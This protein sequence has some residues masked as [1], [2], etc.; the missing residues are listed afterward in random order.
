MLVFNILSAPR[1]QAQA[2]YGNVIGTVTDATGAAV[3]EAK[4]TATD[5]A[6]G[7]TYSAT[8]N[9]DGYYALHNLTP[10]EYRVVVEAGGFKT[11]QRE[12]VPVIVGTSSTVNVALD[13]GAATESITVSGAPPLLETDRAAVSTD[14]SAGQVE[15]LPI[16]NRNFTQLELLLPGSA[17]MP[18]QHGQTEN[19]QG[20]IQINTNGQL[21]S[22]TNFM[23]DGMDN[24]DPVLGI[25]MINP[26]I[27]SVQ[28]FKGTTS[29][30]NAEFSQAGGSVVQ[31]QT[32]S[33][34]NTF[35][36]SLFEFLR[37]DVFQARDP[38]TQHPNTPFPPLRWNQFGGSIG[39]PIKKDK[40]FAFFDYQGTRQRNSGELLTRVPTAAERAGD[41]SAL[42][43]AIYDPTTGDQSTGATGG[44][45]RT[46]FHDL[47]R[48]T[49]ANP[50]GLNIIPKNRVLSQSTNL[51]NLLP[52]PNLTPAIASDPNYTASGTQ[53]FDTNQFDIRVDHYLTSK[54]N[55][56]ARYSY[57]GYHLETPGAFGTAG[58]PQLNGLS[59]EGISNV[60]NQNGVGAVN[61]NLNPSM[62]GDF[63]FGVTRYRVFVTSPDATKMLAA[64]AG[65]PGL[66]DPTRKD[67]W[68]LPDVNV[69]NGNGTSN[70][71]GFQMGY[72]CNC[73]LDEEET[74]YQGASNW[75]K[76]HGNHTLKFG[77]DVRRRVN[78]RLPSDQHRA[79]VFNIA[80]GDTAL[81]QGGNAV[82][83]LALASFLLGDS[84]SFN[85]FGQVSTNQRDLQW[86]MYY[87]GEDIWR[88]TQK[89]TLDYGLRWDTWFADQSLNKGQGGRYDATDNLVRIPGIGGVSMSGGVNTDYNNFSPRIGIAYA[90]SPKTVVRTGYG[91]SY[92]QG[93]F[94]WTFNTLAADVYPSIVNQ[95]LNPPSAY[96]PAVSLATGPSALVFPSIPSNGLLLLPDGI[97]TAYIPRNQPMPYV[98]SWNLTVEQSVFRD[99]TLSVGYVGNVG[100]RLNYGPNINAAVPGAGAFN[101]RRPLFQKFAITQG[102]TEKCDCI[103]SSYNAL[104]IKFTKRFSRNF[105][106]LSSY[107]WA[108]ALNFGEFGPDT[109]QYHYGRDHGPAVFDRASI[110]TLGH[111]VQLPFGRGQ[112]WGANVNRAVDALLGGWQWTGIT[113]VES[114]L[115]FSPTISNTTLNADMSLRPNRIGNPYA[116]VAHNRTKWF[117]PSAFAT[118]AAFTFGNAGRNSLRGPG[119]FTADWGL[120]K[121]FHFTERV[122][123]QFRWEVFNVFNRVNMQNPIND[124]GNPSAGLITDIS[125]PMRDQQFGLHLTF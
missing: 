65:I 82:G 59:F 89:L 56:F 29:N 7:V 32:K 11:Y 42:G 3:A 19:P 86:S 72:Q 44:S 96:F 69:G 112:R 51:L 12:P 74:E 81:N 115:P 95:N 1:T 27:D 104:Q 122:A 98:D 118:P 117:N 114:G 48:A 99:A 34:T 40:L 90:L 85:R 121:Y 8:S 107:T 50:L 93:T 109:D 47:T 66:N 4:V 2:A 26:P 101:P 53:V 38:F 75:T 20:G 31:V 9:A 15:N 80:P 110:F 14:L 67:T 64:E 16:V 77:A 10:G 78:L 100:R 23:I 36:G 123:L 52:L 41:L 37:N 60:R 84:N 113:T 68:G 63:R 17:R 5:I 73:P 62:L 28:E 91:R 94:G 49:P 39:G 76:L 70:P 30:F 45:G 120:D 46:Q 33:G 24:T 88:V 108:K 87:Y 43:V 79:G 124:V 21:F 102:I 35:H 83:G 97:G 57:G 58:G 13:V 6:K 92:F 103:N 54:V 106:L 18:W 71:G 116:G 105:S 111:T 25:I 125:S 55:Y 22:G 119:L 61:W